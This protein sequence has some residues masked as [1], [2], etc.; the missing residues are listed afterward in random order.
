MI[1]K[2]Y[3]C[4][5]G[6]RKTL[7]KYWNYTQQYIVFSDLLL[8]PRMITNSKHKIF[9]HEIKTANKYNSNRLTMINVLIRC[10]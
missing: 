2:L 7:L 3:L 6:L 8:T 9:D 4:I 1:T 10:P 5:K